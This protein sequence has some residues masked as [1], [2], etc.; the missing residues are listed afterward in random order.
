MPLLCRVAENMFWLN[1]YVERAIAIIRV[2]DVTAHLELDS[3]DPDAHGLFIPNLPTAFNSE[4]KNFPN[5]ATRDYTI[6][7]GSPLLTGGSIP[8]RHGCVFIPRSQQ[9]AVRRERHAF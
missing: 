8:Q 3:G 6:A 2:V 4:V 1:R 5:F 7:A 9:L